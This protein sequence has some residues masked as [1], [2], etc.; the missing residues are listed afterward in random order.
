MSI[1]ISKRIKSVLGRASGIAGIYA[2]D[3]RGKMVIVAFH[4]VNDEMP[5]DGLTC[6]AAKFEAFCR[7]FGEHF[8]IVPLS[9]QIAAC[10]DFTDM[11]GTLSITFDDGYQDN[12][13]VAAPIL[14]KLGLPATFFVTSGYI[15][16]SLTAPWDRGLTPAPRWMSWDQL[17]SLKAQGFD[18]GAHTETHVD[19][20]SAEP[21]TVRAELRACRETLEREIDCRVDLFAYPFGGIDNISPASLQLVREAGFSC[22][23]SCYGGVNS[24]VADP[25]HLVRIGIAEWFA[26]PHQFGFELTRQHAR[27][28]A[29]GRPGLPQ[30]A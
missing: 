11:G 23:L 3:F 26:T 10:R 15:G 22:C 5:E 14:R 17:R 24:P 28:G 29:I 1:S 19:L 21:A 13:E 7:F 9:Q 20:G 30:I 8:R 16:S 18:I 12:H 27:L 25:F 2:R 6:S 4:R